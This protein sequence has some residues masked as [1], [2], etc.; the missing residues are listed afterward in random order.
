MRDFEVIVYTKIDGTI[1]IEEFLFTLN[2]KCMPKYCGNSNFL[3]N[4][5]MS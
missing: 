4:M 1:P 2:K 3:K 5:E